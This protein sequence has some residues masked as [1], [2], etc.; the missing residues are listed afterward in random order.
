MRTM[1]PELLF[2]D[3]IGNLAD[4]EALILA[5]G[6][7]VPVVAT[8]HGDDIRSLMRKPSIS[9]LMELSL[10]GAYAVIRSVGGIRQLELGALPLKA[11]C[12]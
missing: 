3:E 1:S 2:V 11:D 7:G 12:R 4:S 5:V 10:F 6:A 9:H 8:A